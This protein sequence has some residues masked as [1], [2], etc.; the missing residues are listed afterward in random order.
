MSREANA[1]IK[2]LGMR[3]HP[4]GG[5]YRE[6]YR[7]NRPG[8]RGRAHST[9]IYFLLKKGEVSHWHR[10]D[11]TEVW[12]FYKGSPLALSIAPARGPAVR[13]VLGIDIAAGEKPQLVVPP[14]AWQ[15]ARSLGTYTLV[16]CTVAPGFDFDRFELAP[17]DFEPA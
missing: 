3:P 1:L 9:G 12:H 16:G 11:A 7:D 5:H 17:P 15:S 10:I 2:A 6:V 14:K 8:G 4:E 13:H